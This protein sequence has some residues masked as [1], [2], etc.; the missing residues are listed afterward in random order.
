MHALDAAVRHPVSVGRSE[1]GAASNNT[2]AV[3]EC[4]PAL[5]TVGLS[6]L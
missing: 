6:A 2:T 5:E 3:D 4:P 1:F